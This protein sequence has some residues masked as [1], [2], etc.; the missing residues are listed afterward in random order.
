MPLSPPA[1]KCIYTALCLLLILVGAIW[2]KSAN[3]DPSVEKSKRSNSTSDEA[4]NTSPDQSNDITKRA[5]KRQPRKNGN[6]AYKRPKVSASYD[7]EAL[8]TSLHTRIPKDS[9]IMTGGYKMKNGRFEFTLITP[10]KVILSDGTEAIQMK[11]LSFKLEADA[12][13]QLGLSDL[14]TDK[15]DSSQHA[16]I[17]SKDD[18]AK[19]MSDLPNHKST[20]SSAPTIIAGSSKKFQISNGSNNGESYE[21]TGTA[22]NV[23]NEETEIKIRIERVEAK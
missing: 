17:W 8:A 15:Q 20:I 4:Q 6:Q 5:T 12:T 11:V 21:L 9:S 16:E 18:V 14:V 7:K 23:E 10:T 19:T 1:K 13:D 22:Y 3:Q 2:M